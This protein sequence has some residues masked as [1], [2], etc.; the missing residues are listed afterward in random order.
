[1]RQYI[2]LIAL[3]AIWIIFSI[4]TDG[5]FF[6]PRNISNL[7]SQ[8]SIVGILA[9]GMTLVIVA[10]HID[11][12]AGSVVAVTGAVAAICN[13][14]ASQFSAPISFAIAILTGILIGAISGF[15]VAYI[16][17]PAFIVTLGGML[18]YRGIVKGI[19]GGETIGPVDENF[20]TI[21]N[22][23][24]SGI[25]AWGLFILILIC[26]IIYTRNKIKTTKAE[27]TF[28]KKEIIVPVILIAVVSA[29]SITLI[30]Y[31]GI[32]YP[33]LVLLV[34]ALLVSFIST[35][36]TFGRYV[37]AIGGNKEAAFYSGIDVKKNLFYVFVIM[38]FLTAVAGIVYTAKLGSATAGAGRNLELDAIAACVIGGTS[39][40]GGKGTIAG[41]LLGSLIMTSLDNGMSLMNVHDFTQDIIKGIILVVAVWIDV[42]GN[43][44][45]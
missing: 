20:Q 29:F 37:Y 4:A 35:M 26:L 33:L 7:L 12:S 3:A 28:S 21:G 36:T 25:A 19:T 11:L 10:G 44:K 13:V 14:W 15:L 17:I 31:R 2:M 34:F 9:T 1:M 16:N 8:T 32:P 40:M 30:N 27:N 6:T 43:K 23:F 38:G 24:F 22:G 39:L 42:T 5:I 45:Q 18:V 41:A